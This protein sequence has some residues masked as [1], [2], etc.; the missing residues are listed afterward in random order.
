MGAHLGVWRFIPSHSPTFPGA[1]DL[2]PGLTSWPTPLQALALVASP[3]LGLRHCM[4]LIT[5][6]QVRFSKFLLIPP[7]GTNGWMALAIIALLMIVWITTLETPFSCQKRQVFLSRLW[8]KSTRFP[9]LS[10]NVHMF[11]HFFFHWIVWFFLRWW[12]DTL[13]FFTKIID[14]DFSIYC[15]IVTTTM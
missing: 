14:S 5:W 4:T 1:W 13:S 7:K 12:L 3:R 11:L 9:T 2:T 15:P 8:K 10:L 6:F